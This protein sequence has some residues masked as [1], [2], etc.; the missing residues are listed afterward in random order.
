[1]TPAVRVFVTQLL[2]RLSS[3]E[4]RLETSEMRVAGL[5]KENRDLR[6]RLATN[7]SNSSIALTSDRSE[8]APPVLL[9]TPAAQ[10]SSNF[11]ATTSRN[12][13]SARPSSFQ[14]LRPANDKGSLPLTTS[15]QRSKPCSKAKRPQG[16]SPLAKRTVNGYHFGNSGGSGG[17]GGRDLCGPDGF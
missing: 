17:C 15:A 12:R 13:Q 6:P 16:C 5:E 3:L 8:P 7:S 11:R 2:A 10:F 14:Q 9:G 4:A 1:M